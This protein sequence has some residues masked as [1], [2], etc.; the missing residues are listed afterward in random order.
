VKG[1][2]VEGLNEKKDLSD[3][4]YEGFPDFFHCYRSSGKDPMIRFILR[5]RE[6]QDRRA[7]SGDG[8]GDWCPSVFSNGWGESLGSAVS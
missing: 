5:Y 4:N 6:D 3:S 1:V 2:E 8:E 7:A